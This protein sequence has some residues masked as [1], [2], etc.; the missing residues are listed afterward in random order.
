M[1]DAVVDK[2]LGLYVLIAVTSVSLLVAPF[3]SLDPVNLPKLCLLVAVAS[4]AAGLVLTKREF[5]RDKSYRTPLLVMGGFILQLFM[6]LLIDNHPMSF[7]FYGTPSRN[8]GFIAYLSLSFILLASIASARYFLIA[9]YVWALIGVGSILGFY[10]IAQSKGYDF[11]QFN[12]AYGSNVFS[13]FGNSNFHSAFMGIVASVALT[14]AV[15]STQKTYFKIL[16]T[17][18]VGLAIYNVSI[19]SQQGYL[20]FLAGFTAALIIYLFKKKHAVFGWSFLVLFGVGITSVLLG[21]LDKGP[22][23]EAIYK[24]SLQTRGFYWRAAANMISHN[25]FFGVGMDGFGDWYR[26]SR[27]SEI[28]ELNAGIASD[29]AHNI[30]LDIGSGGG[31]P[32]MILYLAIIG[33]ALYSIIKVVKRKSEFDVLFSAL[34]AAW[35]A[36]QAQSLISINQLGLGVWGWS[37]TGLIIGYEINSRETS[38]VVNLQVGRKSKAIAEKISAGTLIITFLTTGIGLAIALPPYFAADKF[39]KA[40]QTGDADVIQ[41]AAYLQPYDRSRFIFVAQILQENK[42]EA[43]AIKVLQDA[44]AIY[45]DSFE[46]WNRWSSIPSANPTDIARAKAEMKRLDPYNPDLK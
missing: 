43:R 25:P 20:N 6:V 24:S 40:L 42:L 34:V 16:L 26:R 41:P 17:S 19:S 11:Y 37:L 3:G 46:I 44:S 10:G 23:A 21:I 9:R 15:F 14:L 38:Q 33:L 18:L 35:F 32:L 2:Y 8:T 27:T 36:Y 39:Y 13:S 28:A 30:P 22:L 31:L 7:K 5:L 12:N 45:P 4:V 29:T 1:K